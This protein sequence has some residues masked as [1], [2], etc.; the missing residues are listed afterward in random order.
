MQW[1]ELAEN[2]LKL[3]AVDK[4]RLVAFLSS[5]LETD[6]KKMSAQLNNAKVSM[7]LARKINKGKNKDIDALLE[8]E[9]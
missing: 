7:K 4:A 5:E 2:A 3:S 6:M 9:E 8:C 1:H